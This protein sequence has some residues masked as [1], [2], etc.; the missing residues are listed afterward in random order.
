MPDIHVTYRCPSCG[1]YSRYTRCPSC[2]ADTERDDSSRRGYTEF[3]HA[4]LGYKGL[5]PSCSW[6]SLSAARKAEKH[7]TQ[8]TH[9][10]FE[11]RQPATSAVHGF[12]ERGR[13]RFSQFGVPVD[14]IAE[15]AQG[16]YELTE[17]MKVMVTRHGRNHEAEILKLYLSRGEAMFRLDSPQLTIVLPITSIVSHGRVSGSEHHE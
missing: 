2:G 11:R 5:A 12:D 10:F 1:Y 17:G 16:V 6:E 9:A 7:K 8:V 15:P 14:L 13:I 3:D 4:Q